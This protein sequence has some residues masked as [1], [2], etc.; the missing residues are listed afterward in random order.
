MTILIDIL[1][2]PE[3]I[4]VVIIDYGMGNVGSIANMLKKLGEEAIISN[5]ID[6]IKAS[7]RLILPGVGSFD[8]GMT[9]LV[10]SGILDELERQVH[11]NKKPILGICLGMQLLGRKSD[12]G[13]TEG[14]GWIPF[15]TVSFDKSINLPIPHMG[16]DYVAIC[17]Q[18]NLLVK[19]LSN[20]KLRYYFVHSYHAVCDDKRYS[21]MTCEYGYEFA[22][23][24]NFENIYG[25][26]FHPEK[27]HKFGARLLS[28]FLEV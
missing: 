25:V 4:M 13:K 20:E 12:E 17:D 6:D 14:L 5:K 10:S 3:Y 21:L 26:Q 8:A 24:V 2:C 23:A 9:N 28:N 11:V 19:N 22:A 15:E 1:N 18:S 7:D 16:W 27:S